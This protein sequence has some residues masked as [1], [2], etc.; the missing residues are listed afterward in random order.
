MR[1]FIFIFFYLFFTK[2]SA[3]KEY[4]KWYFGKHAGISFNSNP[5]SAITDSKI[6]SFQS[7]SSICDSSGQILFYSDG[8]TIYNSKNKILKGWQPYKNKSIISSA[9]QGSI[10]LPMPNHPNLYYIFLGIASENYSKFKDTMIMYQIL[11]ADKD[12]GLGEVIQT[13]TEFMPGGIENLAVSKHE[14][15]I[16]Y[17]L[18]SSDFSRKKIFYTCTENGL[19]SSNIRHLNI[20]DT[21]LYYSVKFSPDSKTLFSQRTIDKIGSSKYYAL[22]LYKFNNSTGELSQHINIP[23]K[24]NSGAIRYL[25]FS[26]DS[27]YVYFDTYESAQCIYQLDLKYWDSTKISQSLKKVFQFPSGESV[28][29]L[30]LG[31]DKKIYVFHENWTSKN[32]R[33]VSYINYPE[34]PSLQCDFIF[35]GIDL[36]NGE[37]YYGGPNIPSFWYRTRIANLKQSTIYFCEGDTVDL[38]YKKQQGDSILWNTGENSSTIKVTKQGNYT[39]KIIHSDSSISYD[40]FLVLNKVKSRIFSEK[41]IKLCGNFKEISSTINGTYLWSTNEKKKSI[42]VYDTGIYWLKVYSNFCTTID[43]IRITNCPKFIINIPNAFTPDNN[44]IN[45]EFK[46]NLGDNFYIDFKIYTNWGELI[47][48]EQGSTCSWDGKYNYQFC[49]NGLY[50]YTLVIKNTYSK[51]SKFIKGCIE[52]MR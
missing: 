37:M 1:F 16:D 15:G 2:V 27:R 24:F 26:A 10:I 8:D 28:R 13:Y 44:G 33:K 43:T 35:N 6:F 25:E 12:S 21:M 48:F 38:N 18:L 29:G 20:K 19:I 36:A 31:P 3:Q 42:K 45:D 32:T 11:D 23:T 5:I 17:W 41:E 4:N 49:P 46:V 22:N 51:E 34:K 7:S 9:Y 14:N 30:Q 47:Y 50:F 52:L 40:D 39:L